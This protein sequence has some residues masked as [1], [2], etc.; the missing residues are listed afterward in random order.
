MKLTSKQLKKIIAEE[1]RSVINE[2]VGDPTNPIERALKDP[3]IPPTI[4]KFLA[5]DS[6]EGRQQ[7]VEFLHA[8]FPDEYPA[9]ESEGYQGS[10]EYKKKYDDA[11]TSLKN[12][13][14]LFKML[15]YIEKNF[16]LVD[17]ITF[18]ERG[19]VWIHTYAAPL[20]FKD[21][22]KSMEENLGL[23]FETENVNEYVSGKPQKLDYK[24]IRD[25]TG[26]GLKDG[27]S[28]H[29]TDYYAVAELDFKI[30]YW[31]KMELEKIWRDARGTPTE[32]RDK[33]IQIVL[34]RREEMDKLEHEEI[35]KMLRAQGYDV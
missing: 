13:D 35:M 22:L 7:G 29:L 1:L 15:E 11:M 21:M 23:K 19:K 30:P 28:V 4:K 5:S 3:N 27:G 34:K 20:L 33:Q 10:E 17:D 16:P 14:R 2:F 31:L 25:T 12:I 6:P 18:W 9:E 26:I 24:I 8:L 32:R